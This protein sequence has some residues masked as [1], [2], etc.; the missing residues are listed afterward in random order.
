MYQAVLGHSPSPEVDHL[1]CP[2]LPAGLALGT[3]MSRSTRLREDMFIE[4]ARTVAKAVSEEERAAGTLMPPVAAIRELSGVCW[5][6][7]GWVGLGWA[8][9]RVPTAQHGC[10]LGRIGMRN[11][12][13]G[14]QGGVALAC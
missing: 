5:V 7:L 11:G 1:P 13:K 12:L 2:C 8:R 9:V 4:A 10:L 3:L 6:G 14:A